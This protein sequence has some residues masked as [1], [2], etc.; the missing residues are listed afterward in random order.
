MGRLERRRNDE[1][2]GDRRSRRIA[3]DQAPPTTDGAVA[4]AA[5]GTRLSGDNDTALDD[6]WKAALR[7]N[8]EAFQAAVRPYLR[9]SFQTVTSVGPM[10]ALLRW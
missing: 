9:E 1:F 2:R 7:G 6:A 8:R 4:I 3:D 10:A 5:E